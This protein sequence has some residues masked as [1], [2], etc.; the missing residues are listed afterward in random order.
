MAKNYYYKN[1]LK[2]NQRDPK[3]H[4]KTINSIL[5]KGNEHRTIILN[6]PSDNIADAFNNHFKNLC[7][8]RIAISKNI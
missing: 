5:G 3:T 7:F 2:N 4:W 8:A 6:P 1:K